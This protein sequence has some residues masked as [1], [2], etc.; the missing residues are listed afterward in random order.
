MPQVQVNDITLNY[1][2]EGP[3]SADL[4]VLVNGL[5]DDLTTWSSQTPALLAAG[6]Q[7]LTYDNRGKH[8]KGLKPYSMC[9][10]HLLTLCL[11]ILL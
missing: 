5:A 6:Y 8:T 3:S 10:R 9:L 2:R 1:S 7:I 4:I 11:S